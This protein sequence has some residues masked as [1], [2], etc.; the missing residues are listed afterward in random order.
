MGGASTLGVFSA[1]FK[2]LLCKKL[3]WTHYFFGTIK[4]YDE[5]DFDVRGYGAICGEKAKHKR[6]KGKR[7]WAAETITLF[8]A[9][10]TGHPFTVTSV[11]MPFYVTAF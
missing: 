3:D 5:Y 6:E 10:S 7:N 4:L 1:D 9:A 8:G 2:G 11:E